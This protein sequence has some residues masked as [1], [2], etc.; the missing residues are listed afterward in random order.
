MRLTPRWFTAAAMAAVALVGCSGGSKSPAT[1]SPQGTGDPIDLLENT[2]FE[3]APANV[4]PVGETALGGAR[5]TVDM[6][7]MSA[8]VAPLRSGT[9][10]DDS[11]HLSVQNFLTARHIAVD[12][13]TA[14]AT[15]IVVDYTISHPFPGPTDVNA[16]PNGFSNRADLGITGRTVILADVSSATGNTFFTDVVANTDLV[17][18]ADGYV[19]PRG[20]I[21]QTSSMT[22]NAFPFMLLVDEALGTEGSRVGISNGGNPLGN[23]RADQG[24]WQ[25]TN[26]VNGTENNGW[27]GYDYLH[28]GQSSR[29][30]LTLRRTALTG[31]PVSLD[32]VVLAK[33]TDPRGGTTSTEKR[34][35]RLPE[36]PTFDTN[37]FVY[38]LPYAALDVARARFRGESGGLLPN[39]AA[40]ASTVRVTVRDWDARA[41]V[42]SRADLSQDPIIDNVEPGGP[43]VPTVDVDVPGVT[44]SPVSLTLNDDDTP[45]GAE[46]DAA[47]ETGYSNDPLY[48]QGAL[49]NTAG[50]GGGQTPGD[51]RGM[52]R[53]TDISNSQ[54]RSA[55]EFQLDPDLNLL[56]SNKMDL[57]IF[58]T[59]DVN[60]GGVA[61]DPPNAAVEIQG[62]ANPQVASGGNVVFMV[63]SESDTEGDTVLY[64]VDT[65]YT[66]TFNPD[67]NDIDPPAVPGTLYTGTAPINTGTT[68]LMRTAR[69]AY[70]DAAH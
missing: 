9:A 43:G 67:G 1:P 46:G 13:V 68:N 29:N 54:D 50:V 44:A 62:G 21:P 64:D 18:L 57:Q 7:G 69:V 30:S 24:G 5:L 55:Y 56:T 34:A 53:V 48:F 22:A 10:T 42:T 8:S 31:G 3:Q 4:V 52:I 49:V 28:Q 16:A 66:G 36:T 58:Q 39:Q 35:N 14:T 40:S 51:K 41:Q 32:M 59:L 27:T 11:Y 6:A 65:E 19:Q 17:A 15:D 12:R 33:Y 70:F 60:L 63:L 47:P 25:A 2:L 37:K 20:L 45:L 26:I 61:N 38:R 23:Y